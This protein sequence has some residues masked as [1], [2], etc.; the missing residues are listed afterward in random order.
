MSV[1]RETTKYLL[2]DTFLSSFIPVRGYVVII[3]S[4]FN[5]LKEDLQLGP[6]FVSTLYKRL[7][8]KKR[9]EIGHWERFCIFISNC[10][11]P[12]QGA[13]V[14]RPRNSKAIAVVHFIGGIF[15]GA[16]PQLTYR[17]FLERLAEE[18]VNHKIY[19]ALNIFG[20]MFSCK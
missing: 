12:S 5:S 6:F 19:S 4:C 7:H 20:A 15:V 2:K 11:K 16:A 14:L 10:P 1:V 9:K 3:L 8:K 13:W 18:W 17:F